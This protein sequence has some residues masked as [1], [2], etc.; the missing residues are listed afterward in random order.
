VLLLFTFRS[1]RVTSRIWGH[2]RFRE[3]STDRSLIEYLTASTVA[4]SA[5]RFALI[6]FLPLAYFA[7][8]AA[9][10]DMEPR[11]W[12]QLPV[13]TDF[14]GV[15]Y[16]YSAGEIHVDPVLMIDNARAEVNTVVAAYSRYFGL[17]DMTARLDVQLPVVVGRWKGLLDGVPQTVTR[18]GLADPR[19]RLSVNFLGA[20]ALEEKEFQEYIK[21]NEIRTIAGLGLAMRVPLGQYMDDKLINLGE[22]RFSFEPQLGVVHTEGEW[23]FEVTSSIFFYT[24]NDDFFGGNTLEQ[25]P[26]YAVQAHVVRT[27]EGMFWV[28]VG[29]AYGGDGESQISGVSKND[30]RSNLL[31]GINCGL[32]LPPMN[33]FRIGYF[34]QETL[35]SL[36]IDS[37]SVLISWSI[38]F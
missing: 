3:K 22:N 35:N 18:E 33:A 38:R 23:S 10:Q 17:E 32:S 30:A 21:S 19:I 25:S 4:R 37:N 1:T 7:T 34:R 36:G 6:G 27:F 14:A 26:L 20:P 13:G 12:N 9:A 11:R 31:Y 29:A 2:R 16:I 5:C 15:S 28:S 24:K 8:E